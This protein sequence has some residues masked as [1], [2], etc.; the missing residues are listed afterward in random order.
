M[1]LRFPVTSIYSG[2]G[3]PSSSLGGYG[4]GYLQLELRQG[5]PSVIVAVWGPYDVGRSGWGEGAAI[6][7]KGDPGVINRLRD[8]GTDLPQRGIVD[9]RGAGV[10][11]SDDPNGARTVVTIPGEPPPDYAYRYTTVSQSVPNAQ[12]FALA[13]ED[14]VGARGVTWDA[15]LKAMVVAK[16]GLYDV[17]AGM[18]W[19]QN[20]TG[21]RSF[22]LKRN[23]LVPGNTLA[24][25]E[26]AA[27]SPPIRHSVSITGVRLLAGDA[28]YAS[29]Y[30]TSGGAL[31][32]V[33]FGRSSFLSVAYKGPS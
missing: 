19:A 27:A 12:D 25:D 23:G 21:T 9:F 8:E 7:G 10:A 28:I 11:A 29:C 15:A 3:P 13:F 1:T 14:P 2:V 17:S 5:A 33:G 18:S 20:T 22:Q 30:Q 16:A 6:V 26:K 4:D 31:D 24:A 32:A